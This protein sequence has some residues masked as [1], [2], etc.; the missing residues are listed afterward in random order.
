MIFLAVVITHRLLIAP[1]LVSK[2]SGRCGCF[3]AIVV[4]SVKT[5]PTLCLLVYRQSARSTRGRT[6]RTP[7][8]PHPRSPPFLQIVRAEPHIATEPH[9]RN[10]VRSCLSEHPRRGYRQQPPGLRRIEKGRE[11]HSRW[12]GRILWW[13]RGG[14][15]G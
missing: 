3:N 7:R 8:T 11:R 1:T 10:P 4:S 15:Y 9:M 5:P 2:S 14:H 12:R 13:L 6:S